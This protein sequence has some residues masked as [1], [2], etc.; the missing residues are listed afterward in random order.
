LVDIPLSLCVSSA[1]AEGG[2]NGR[3]S[4][5][6]RLVHEVLRH[7][8]LGETSPLASYIAS[9]PC[10]FNEPTFWPPGSPE[11]LVLG[12]SRLASSSNATVRRSQR[13]AIKVAEEANA[14]AGSGCTECS[15]ATVLWAAAIQ[16]TRAFELELADGIHVVLAPLID[17]VNH[18]VEDAAANAHFSWRVEGE[19][20]DEGQEDDMSR[21]RLLLVASR[22]IAAGEQI[23]IDY[24]HEATPLSLWQ[25]YGI[26]PRMPTCDAS[27]R[28]PQRIEAVEVCFPQLLTDPRLPVSP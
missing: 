15:P 22:P 16:V 18:A 25:R 12:A 5:G 24:D 7:Y 13:A 2:A 3:T 6:V 19:G 26:P 20:A 17:M 11:M 9:L 1:V 27:S 23:L 14:R 8:L 21:I 10:A 28:I 4:A